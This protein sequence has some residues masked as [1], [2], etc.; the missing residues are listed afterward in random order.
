MLIVVLLRGWRGED[1]LLGLQ[2]AKQLL[3]DSVLV[4]ALFQNFVGDQAA[5][6]RTVHHGH[7]PSGSLEHFDVVIAVPESDD[8]C[9]TYF[10]LIADFLQPCTLVDVPVD[11]LKEE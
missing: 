11:N 7:A 6:L 5:G 2:E 10:E 8:I 4:V 3:G 9:D 1:K